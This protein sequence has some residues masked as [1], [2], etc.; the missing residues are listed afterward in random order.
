[1]EVS[2]VAAGERY[3]LFEMSA[4][5]QNSMVSLIISPLFAVIT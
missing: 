5:L 1:M 2:D 3:C 4:E